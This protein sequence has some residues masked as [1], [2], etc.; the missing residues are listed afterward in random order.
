MFIPGNVATG[1]KSINKSSEG[2]KVSALLGDVRS[3]PD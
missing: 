1:R 2:V 3:G